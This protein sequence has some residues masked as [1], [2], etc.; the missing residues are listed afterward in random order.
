[1]SIFTFRSRLGDT[2]LSILLKRY[3]AHRCSSIEGYPQEHKSIEDSDDEKSDGGG[4]DERGD[5][6]QEEGEGESKTKGMSHGKKNN[7]SGPALHWLLAAELL[8]K[9]GAVLCRLFFVQLAAQSAAHANLFFNTQQNSLFFDSYCH[10]IY[11]GASWDV[12]WRSDKK[13]TQLSVFVSSLSAPCSEEHHVAMR[14][15]LTR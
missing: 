12:S 2:A 8:V 6:G 13:E 10:P 14:A 9:S 5:R 7:P 1:M 4:S 15:I 11:S 3:A